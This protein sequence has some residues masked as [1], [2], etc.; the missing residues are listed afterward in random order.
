VSSRIREEFAR[1][2]RNYA[3]RKHGH[4]IFFSDQ[5]LRTPLAFDLLNLVNERSLTNAMLGSHDIYR[6][7]ST[8][9]LIRSIRVIRGQKFS[10]FRIPAAKR[11]AGRDLSSKPSPT[12]SQPCT[13]KINKNLTLI[14]HCLIVRNYTGTTICIG[15]SAKKRNLNDFLISFQ[16]RLSRK[17][18]ALNRQSKPTFNPSNEYE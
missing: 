16:L 15:N 3:R 12:W 1:F 11:R 7:R 4:S 18:E 14:Q 6:S 10:L 13:P 9:T 17:R 2:F 5:L 8:R